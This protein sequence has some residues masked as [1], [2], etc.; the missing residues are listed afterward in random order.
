MVKYN[1]LNVKLSGLSLNKLKIV[2]KNQT[3]VT[4]KMNMRMS[5]GN[6]L[7]RELLSTTT[8]KTN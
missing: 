7:P 5:N 2:V 8:Q 6:I 4:L 1:K 3:S